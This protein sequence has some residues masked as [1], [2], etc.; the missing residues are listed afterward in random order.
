MALR[1]SIAST[2]NLTCLRRA[3]PRHSLFIT[4]NPS[5]NL[6]QVPVVYPRRLRPYSQK[7]DQISSSEL[8]EDATSTLSANSTLSR[9]PESSLGLRTARPPDRFHNPSHYASP[10]PP[11][12]LQFTE[13]GPKS[14]KNSESEQVPDHEWELR[15]GRAIYVLQET[16]PHF[17]ETG[18]ITQVDVTTGEPKT[19]SQHFH[20][21]IIDSAAS[22]DFLSSSS[23]T[24]GFSNG[25]HAGYDHQASQAE[26]GEPIYSPKVRLQYTPPAA[27]PAPFPKTFHLEGLP[28]YLASSSVVRRTMMTLYSHL[29]VTLTKVSVFTEP[30]PNSKPPSSDSSYTNASALIPDAL[31]VEGGLG[32]GVKARN[33]SDDGNS[34]GGPE[35]AGTGS[36]ESPQPDKPRRRKI[37]REKYL[38]VRQLVTGVNRVSGKVGE[39]EVES[40]YTF[41]PISGLIL[42]HTVNSIQ[43]APHL[44]VYTW[45]LASSPWISS[46]RALRSAQEHSYLWTAD[47]ISGDSVILAFFIFGIDDLLPVSGCTEEVDVG[48][49][50][51]IIF[52][53]LSE[54]SS[55]V[56]PGAWE[57]QRVWLSA[58]VYLL[59][60][61]DLVGAWTAESFSAMKLRLH[62]H[63][64]L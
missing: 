47:L 43:P 63:K 57:V 51:K 11:V 8:T 9:H 40:L 18:L 45:I 28:M 54:H 38:L 6:A 5:P 10:A 50:K 3:K 62:A 29:E 19:P 64:P 48:C 56:L 24:N 20:I 31:S 34:L 17:F 26:E 7:A 12:R 4:P 22:L 14:P 30:P 27:L 58:L 49:E 25:E 55:D 36:G 33:D 39:W 61:H 15:T 53:T 35:R 32:H 13:H 23:S 42:Q 16:L 41:S 2:S 37:G 21:P 44:A 52:E 59:L 1:Q 46:A 60:V